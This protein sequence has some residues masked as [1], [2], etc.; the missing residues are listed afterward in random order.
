MIVSIK[1]KN[2]AG[3]Y[4]GRAYSYYAE[5]E[6]QPQIGDL[7]LAPVRDEETEAMIV[8]LDIDPAEVA[9]IELK[10]ITKFADAKAENMSL[11]DME[12]PAVTQAEEAL[13]IENAIILKQLPIIEDRMRE[14]SAKVVERVT[15]SLS[16]VCTEDTYKDVKKERAE[17]NKEFEAL[18]TQRKAVK[19][20]ILAPYSQFEDTYKECVA[21]PYK[22]ADRQL[23]EKI[24]E[25]END[26]KQE[27]EWEVKA[28]FPEY[29]AFLGLDFPEFAEVG[30]K[31]NMTD[32]VK[33]LKGE[34]K[35]LLDRIAEDVAAVRGMEHAD[36]IL[37]EYKR[38]RVLSTAI[39]RVAARHE[40]I[41]REKAAAEARAAKEAER[42][43]AAAAVEQVRQEEAEKAAAPPSV[44]A[45][46]A[47]EVPKPEKRYK[48]GFYVYGTR[49]EL[50]KLKDFLTEGG[51]E[52][53]QL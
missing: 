42:R 18:E 28:Y 29:R 26:L 36:E 4:K 45:P 27:K 5:L 23:K 25:V 20:A 8:G 1:Y 19:S 38:D 43:A 40:A 46:A 13:S 33:K 31:I 48:T 30:I 53:E 50:K 32:S 49:E 16:L 41:E 6:R 17:L 44:N 35:E 15:H 24:S 39:A 7:V 14:L 37:V 21:E 47:V 12:L 2:S 34:A 10:T 52:Y 11:E 22:T 9:G 3:E 51:Y